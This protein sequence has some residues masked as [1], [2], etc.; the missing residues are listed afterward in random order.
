MKPR[1]NYGEG[2]VRLGNMKAGKEE[3]CTGGGRTVEATKGAKVKGTTG[4]YKTVPNPHK[5]PRKA[6]T[7]GG[8]FSVTYHLFILVPV[9]Q[10]KPVRFPSFI[11]ISYRSMNDAI[12]FRYFRLAFILLSAHSSRVKL[13]V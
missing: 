1:V 6:A 10:Q 11:I 9:I 4:R 5:H 12:L 3:Y 7:T 2:K 13:R 8:F